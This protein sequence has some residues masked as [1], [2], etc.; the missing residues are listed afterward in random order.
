MDVFLSPIAFTATFPHD[1]SNPIAKRTI[2]TPAGPRH[3]DDLIRWIAP[4]TLTG[5]PA[6]AAPIGLGKSG[7]PIGLQIMG[8]YWEDATPITFAKL[9][10][11]QI[12][13]FTAPAGYA[14]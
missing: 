8:P 3:Y 11:Q 12:G 14:G 13:G 5:C 9:L 2:A 7:L 10:A 1:H 4:P 6:T